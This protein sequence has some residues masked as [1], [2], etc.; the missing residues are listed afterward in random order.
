MVTRV[1]Y[2]VEIRATEFTHPS[3]W[4]EKDYL[5]RQ[6]DIFDDINKAKEFIANLESDML[7]DNEYFTIYVIEYDEDNEEMGY[8][9][10]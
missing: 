1:E 9:P 2:S 10:W 4:K 7:S 5:V 8:Y 3:G 6:L